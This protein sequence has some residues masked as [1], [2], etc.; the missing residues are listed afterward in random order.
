MATLEWDALL[1]E[2]PSSFLCTE[3]IKTIHNSCSCLKKLLK[4]AQKEFAKTHLIR[5]KKEMAEKTLH[6]KIHI[7]LHVVRGEGVYNPN[8]EKEKDNPWYCGKEKKKKEGQHLP[9]FI[10]D[11]LV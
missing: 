11:L 9:E 3:T 6:L 5:V 1:T 8:L 2:L 4:A 10:V 7:L